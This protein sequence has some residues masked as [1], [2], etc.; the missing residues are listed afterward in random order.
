MAGERILVIDD[1]QQIREFIVNYVLKPNGFQIDSARDG[2]EGLRKAIGT[3][4]PDLIIIDYVMPKLNGIQVMQ[5]LIGRQLFIPTILITSHGS[6][7]VAVQLFR[8]G[9]RDYLIKPF[10][11][12]E[13]LSTIEHALTEARLRRERDALNIDLIEV[14]RQLEER[15]HDLNVLQ[16]ISQS[17]TAMIT[18]KSVLP[19]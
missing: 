16:E 4:N 10:T 1:S 15:V 5:A 7:Q 3:L 12:E 6:E 2:R 18:G 17:V 11:A 13:L 14:K 8:L 9:V 19:L